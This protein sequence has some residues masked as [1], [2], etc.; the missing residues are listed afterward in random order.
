MARLNILSTVLLIG[1]YALQETLGQCDCGQELNASGSCVFVEGINVTAGRACT[2]NTDRF[3]DEDTDTGIARCQCGCYWEGNLCDTRVP[4]DAI[5]LVIGN[6]VP[7]ALCL[8]VVAYILYRD[9]KN[10]STDWDIPASH[11]VEPPYKS[12]GPK[13]LL[14]YRLA[15][16]IL[17]WTI[18]SIQLEETSGQAMRAF[19][20]WNWSLLTLYF[21][22]GLF[23]SVKHQIAPSDRKRLNYLERF[24][25]A[26]MVA[27]VV[28]VPFVAIIFWG[29]LFPTA[30]PEFQVFLLGYRSLI[31]HGFNIAIM[32]IDFAMI[33]LPIRYWTYIFVIFWAAFYC[34]FHSAE[35]TAALSYEDDFRCEVY[36]FLKLDSPLFLPWTIGLLV[37]YFFFHV[38]A[39]KL[40]D[41]KLKFQEEVAEL[42]EGK[43][44]EVGL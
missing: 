18:Y 35:I 32:Y 29:V 40:S 9:K 42:E 1:C 10:G 24:F 38:I 3:C 41:L 37:V 8:A 21:T 16:A 6:G 12:I 28:S 22:I 15:I 26:I 36:F 43:S 39:V 25:W 44:K 30:S 11:C 33:T 14:V 31:Q 19:T 13:P 23:L 34:L 17:A 2:L 20:V 27:E 7:L 4:V 5:W